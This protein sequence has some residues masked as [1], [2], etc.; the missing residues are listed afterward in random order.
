MPF[1]LRLRRA[2]DSARC[3]SSTRTCTTPDLPDVARRHGSEDRRQRAQGV[4]RR[5]DCERAWVHGTAV[6]AASEGALLLL[7]RGQAGACAAGVG[8]ALVG[9]LDR[10][11]ER[12]VGKE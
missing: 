4:A 6:G 8:W 10:S 11:E 1:A 5:R 3:R 12:R 7:R 9:S 2:L